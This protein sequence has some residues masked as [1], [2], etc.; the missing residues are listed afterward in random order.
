MN[1]PFVQEYW[2]AAYVENETLEK[3]NA[4]DVVECT[5]DMNMIPSIWAFK[6]TCFP[7]GIITKFKAQFC[8]RVDCQIEGVNYFKTYAHAVQ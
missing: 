8:V 5:P 7:D 3:M 2:D 4:W 1:G 6:F